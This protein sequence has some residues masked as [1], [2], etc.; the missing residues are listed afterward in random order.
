MTKLNETEIEDLLTRLDGWSKGEGCI[1]KTYRF[2]NFMRA[3]MFANA[4]GYIAE[5]VNHH[6]DIH[7]HYNEVTLRNWTH[8]ASGVTERDFALAEKIDAMADQQHLIT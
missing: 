3:L 8:V 4:V 1:E 7:I 2:K 6:P 5:S